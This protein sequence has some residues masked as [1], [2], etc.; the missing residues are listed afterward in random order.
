MKLDK[1]GVY[2]LVGGMGGLGRSL[3]KMLVADGACKL[4]FLNRSGDSSKEAQQLLGE[5]REKSVAALAIPCDVYSTT[6]LKTALAEAESKLDGPIRGCFQCAMVLR[7]VLFENMTYDDWIQSTRPKVQGSKNL[8]DL[9]PNTTD[10][11]I[12]LSSFCGVFGN[13]GQANYVAGCGFQDALAHSR[14][15]RGKHA[16]SIDLG[17]MR[18]V[19]RLAEEGAVGDIAK[20]EKVW[21]I[22][23]HE[24]VAL[25]RL[26]MTPDQTGSQLPTGLGTK[27]GS[28]AAGIE[29]PYYF[30]AD[31]RFGIV[32]R[33]GA[34]KIEDGAKASG[35]GAGQE[36]VSALLS[37]AQSLSEATSAVLSALVLRVSRMLGM[38][39]EELDTSRFLYSYGVDSLAAIELVN[40]ALR[41]CHSRIAVFDVMAGLPMTA[42]SERVAAKS[43]LLAKGVAEAL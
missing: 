26:C 34:G 39:P 40:W 6:S 16:V 28:I 4:C 22:R 24:F 23:E 32:A 7:D 43:T 18:E 30:D 41:E 19:G 38:A 33:T 10:F 9:L 15:T 8:D 5:L 29:P 42:F 2:V 35:D 11:F 25:M 3:A 14:R 21:G 17:L 36:P 20:W 37:K 31:A 12:M 27:A 1:D 13:R